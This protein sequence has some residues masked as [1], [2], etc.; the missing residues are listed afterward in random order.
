MSRE[1]YKHAV[2]DAQVKEKLYIERCRNYLDINK[3]IEEEMK[4]LDWFNKVEAEKKKN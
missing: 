3:F 1:C 4:N 2:R